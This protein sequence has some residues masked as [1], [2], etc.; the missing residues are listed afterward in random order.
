[1]SIKC[2][3]QVWKLHTVIKAA[4]SCFQKHNT[5]S[6]PKPDK[7]SAS[8]T[9]SP[10]GG[11]SHPPQTCLRQQRK[12]ALCHPQKTSKLHQSRQIPGYFCKQMPGL[13]PK[14]ARSD[15]SRTAK[16]PKCQVLT[17]HNSGGLLRKDAAGGGT[18]AHP[19][20]CR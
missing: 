10:E 14:T 16:P 5:F 11:K 13:Q 4:S 9:S 8:N 17:Y 6:T 3:Q 12:R 15:C 18:E 7:A 2:A 1:M 20:R 19:D